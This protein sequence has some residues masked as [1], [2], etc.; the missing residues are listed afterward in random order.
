MFITGRTW[1][2]LV[3]YTPQ[4]ATI[5]RML[6]VY[7]YEA[8]PEKMDKLAHELELFDGLINEYIEKM[9]GEK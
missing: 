7:R 2:D 8:T 3:I 1:W 4:L 6:T 5:G 9:R